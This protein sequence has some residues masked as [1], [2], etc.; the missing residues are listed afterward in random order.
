MNSQDT[1][2]IVVDDD[3]DILFVLGRK[4]RAAG[5]EPLLAAGGEQA[6]A[7]MDAHPHCERMITDVQ[8]PGLGG[9]AWM[10]ILATQ[11]AHWSIIVM[12]RVDTDPGLFV[13][14]PKPLDIENVM[15]HF[16]RVE[17]RMLPQA[18]VRARSA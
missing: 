15:Q 3:P 13:L 8:M 17:P 12:S 16:Q 4:L 2:V 10:E 1:Q 11:C 18:R 9:A 5:F 7:L 14:A 6:L